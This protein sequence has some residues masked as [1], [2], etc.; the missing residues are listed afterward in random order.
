LSELSLNA[1]LKQK[2]RLPMSPISLKVGWNQS[3]GQQCHLP[4][5]ESSDKSEH[6]KE[7][8]CN[9]KTAVLASANTEL[10][11][12]RLP[13]TSNLTRRHKSKKMTAVDI[14]HHPLSR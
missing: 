3:I 2:Y 13:S 11:Q 1:G 14:H 4:P 10:G 9:V 7:L 12:S 6:S 5:N 8:A